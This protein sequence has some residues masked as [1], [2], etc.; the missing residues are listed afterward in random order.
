MW[1][2]N[3]NSDHQP[4]L[5]L[6]HSKP[7]NDLANGFSPNNYSHTTPMLVFKYSL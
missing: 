6:I 5:R 2:I 7:K 4:G 3:G 1:S